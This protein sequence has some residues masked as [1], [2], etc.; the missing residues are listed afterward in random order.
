MRQQEPVDRVDHRFRGPRIRVSDV[1]HLHHRDQQ[2]D[3]LPRVDSL[4]WL[5]PWAGVVAVAGIPAPTCSLVIRLGRHAVPTPL[6]GRFQVARIPRFAAQATVSMLT[7]LRLRDSQSE[8]S[9][10]KSSL[11]SL[12]SFLELSSRVGSALAAASRQEQ[13]LTLLRAAQFQ[14]SRGPQHPQR[15]CKSPNLSPNPHKPAMTIHWP[16]LRKHN[17][18]IELCCDASILASCAPRLWERVTDLGKMLC[19]ISNR[20]FFTIA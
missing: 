13:T 10:L 11:L 1:V 8:L 3:L 14:L 18:A 16:H 19:Y 15:L 5:L 17:E 20:L 9:S 2:S 6:I 4:S 7:G 12:R